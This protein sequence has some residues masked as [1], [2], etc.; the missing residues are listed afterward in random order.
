MKLSII[1]V[2]FNSANTILRT[3]DLVSCQSF[4]YFEN[5][6]IDGGFVDIIL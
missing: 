1:T 4:K 3:L 5:I 2:C 6:V